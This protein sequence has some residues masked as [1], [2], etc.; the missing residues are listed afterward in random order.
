MLA[1]IVGIERRSYPGVVVVLDVFRAFTTAA[2]AFDAGVAQIEC[3]ESLA[4]AI[5]LKRKTPTALLVGEEHGLR[6]T[7]FD[8]G[9]S[10]LPFEHD[11]SYFGGRSL[12][13][14]TS[15]GTRGL[16]WSEASVVY[17]A[18]AVNA[19]ATVSHVRRNYQDQS[20]HLVCTEADQGEDHACAAYMAALLAGE[21]PSAGLL[22]AEL[23][24]IAAVEV[25]RIADKYGPA[26]AEMFSTDYESC[27]R[28]DRSTSVMQV[29]RSLP[30]RLVLRLAI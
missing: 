11:S 22:E 1:E 19:A 12:I 6:P 3:V 7:G 24:K 8:L 25:S 13:Q 26:R 15:N 27:V 14:R 30:G 21:S 10:P 2:S 16:A 20:V 28:V 23:R 17:A 18:S 5:E 4:E 29:D 9:N